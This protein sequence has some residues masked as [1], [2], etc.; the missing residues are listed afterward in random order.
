MPRFHTSYGWFGIWDWLHGTDAKF[1]QSMLHKLRHFRLM[2]GKAARE[3][4]PDSCLAKE[5]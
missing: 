2:S 4:F 1:D 5:E 3:H